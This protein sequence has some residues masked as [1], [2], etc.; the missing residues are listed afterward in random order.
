MAGSCQ[1]ENEPSGFIICGEGGGVGGK[2]I[3]LTR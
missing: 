1:W 3:F 2:G